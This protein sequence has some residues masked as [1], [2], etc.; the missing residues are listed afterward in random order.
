MKLDADIA[1]LPLEISMRLALVSEQ[2]GHNS[3]IIAVADVLI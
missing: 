1:R 2:P 3:E